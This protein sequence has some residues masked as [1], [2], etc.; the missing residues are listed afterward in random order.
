VYKNCRELFQPIE[1][2][3]YHVWNKLK[4]SVYKNWREL[5]QPIELLQKEV[6]I[7]CLSHYKISSTTN[8]KDRVM[9]QSKKTGVLCNINLQTNVIKL[10]NTMPIFNITME[11]IFCV[12]NLLHWIHTHIFEHILRYVPYYVCFIQNHKAFH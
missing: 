1:L 12:T 11:N 5:F 7:C 2:V 8:I 6:K 10:K 4:Q 3:N 9:P